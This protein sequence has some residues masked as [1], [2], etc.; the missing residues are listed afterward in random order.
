MFVYFFKEAYINSLWN[1]KIHCSDGQTKKKIFLALDCYPLFV[2]RQV[3]TPTD[4][5]MQG[6]TFGSELLVVGGF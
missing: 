3:K 6:N 2:E 5:V 4:F 1:V